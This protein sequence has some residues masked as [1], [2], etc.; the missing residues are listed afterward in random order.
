M[1]Y[2]V[3]NI[4]DMF[5]IPPG[6]GANRSSG[7]SSNPSD[8][9][10]LTDSQFLFGSQFCPD[11]SQ[12]TSLELPAQSKQQ[13][14]SQHNSQDSDPSVFLKY[15]TKPHLY[16]GDFKDMGS[17]LH[18][19]AGKSKGI[20]EQFEE[21]KKKAKEKS[22]NEQLNNLVSNIQENIQ[23]LQMTFC[24]FEENTDLRCKTI[25]DSVKT[26]SKAL[27]DSAAS[28]HGLILKALSAKSNDEQVLLDLEEKIH[29]KDTEITNI[30]SNVQL[31]VECVDIIKSQQCEQHL[32]LSEKLTWLSDYMKSSENKILNELQ[33]IHLVPEV[34]LHL[35]DDTTQTSPI[36]VQD[37]SLKD[38]I[39][40]QFKTMK[41]CRD[42][43]SLSQTNVRSSSDGT[44]NTPFREDLCLK[45]SAGAFKI[46]HVTSPDVK[47][48]SIDFDSCTDFFQKGPEQSDSLSLELS[49]R[50]LV[51][52]L[53]NGD[54]TTV[55]TVQA[56]QHNKLYQND[57]CTSHRQN[58]LF[59]LTNPSIGT[60]NMLPNTIT[61]KNTS[62]IKR[63]K[64]C[65]RKINMRK[66]RTHVPMKKNTGTVSKSLANSSQVKSGNE[67]V[68]W[69]GSVQDSQKD[70]FNLYSE[71]CVPSLPVIQSPVRKAQQKN[72]E[73]CSVLSSH[74]TT[75][76]PSSTKK[77]ICAGE[78]MVLS[79]TEQKIVHWDFSSQ[80]SHHLHY[81]IKS[82]NDMTWLCPS[83]PLPRNIRNPAVLPTEQKTFLSL[84]FDSSDDSN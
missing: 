38:H 53:T 71:S 24:Q 22:D 49:K 74:Q 31:L 41:T 9:S 15:Q 59:V 29:K 58:N 37:M 48:P 13:K 46:S 30:R 73:K 77:E 36:I 76:H 45:D 75:E 34:P 56:L 60:E 25:L 63:K 44:S 40:S 80:G 72:G 2:N 11:I 50:I 18:F 84:F 28:Q 6:T 27:Q 1:N 61:E 82:E 65:K 21:N 10:S 20:L 8:Y 26:V 79:K 69:E 83:S 42:T 5:S 52:K 64:A 47:D 43:S 57:H 16:S 55:K 81:S 3:W 51:E 14:N 33:K 4:K 62:H 19:G 54:S 7:R 78:S 67:S 23:G 70:Y 66:K 32:E 68:T 12:P 35:K 17:F 39:K